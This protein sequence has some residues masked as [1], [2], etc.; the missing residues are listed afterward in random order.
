MRARERKLWNITGEILS[1]R[2]RKTQFQYRLRHKISDRSSVFYSVKLFPSFGEIESSLIGQIYKL[3]VEQLE[4]LT[5]ILL[6]LPT[7]NALE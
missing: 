7:I 6:I 2:W 1:K 3:S 4:K 5:G